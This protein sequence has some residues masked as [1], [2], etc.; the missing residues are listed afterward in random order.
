M[1]MGMIIAIYKTRNENLETLATYKKVR[2][3]IQRLDG[4]EYENTGAQ[5]LWLP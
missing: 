5:E 4:S 2:S 1:F 3:Q